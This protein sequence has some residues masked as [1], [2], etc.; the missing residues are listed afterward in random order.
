MRHVIMPLLMLC[1]AHAVAHAQAVRADDALTT[2]QRE[3]IRL[4]A[5]EAFAE[6]VERKRDQPASANVKFLEAASKYELLLEDGVVN[7]KLC[8][9]LGNAY[10]HAGRIGEAIHAYRLAEELIPGDDRLQQNLAF[11]RQQCLTRLDV[12]GTAALSDALLGWHDALSMPVRLGVLLVAWTGL[13]LVLYVTRGRGV[14]RAFAIIC[15]LL[16]IVFGTSVTVD[17][18]GRLG[19]DTLIGRD[20]VLVR[21]DITL[22]KGNGAGYDPAYE[23]PLAAGVECTIRIVRAGWTEV[24]LPNNAAGWVPAEALRIVRLPEPRDAAT[25]P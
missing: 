15:I 14:G 24:V 13:W 20:A 25:P 23:E 10:M 7:G 1:L 22:R 8:Y 3:A 18:A 6:G 4:E 19:D 9:N 16:T 21:S 5:D 17:V 12:V 11:A 2:S